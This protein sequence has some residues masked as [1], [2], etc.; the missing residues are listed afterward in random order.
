MK[1]AGQR[2]KEL[3]QD[4]GAK[5]S[6]RQRAPMGASPSPRASPRAGAPK[7]PSKDNAEK[8]GLIGEKRSKM[9]T[10]K[11]SKL[12]LTGCLYDGDGR[13]T[14]LEKVKCKVPRTYTEIW[15]KSKSGVSYLG[16]IRKFARR[17]GPM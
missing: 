10:R 12:S 3:V 13:L 17:G 5:T 14:N 9:S 16:S 6:R 11:C 4:M 2:V 8:G 7:T 1:D 15:K